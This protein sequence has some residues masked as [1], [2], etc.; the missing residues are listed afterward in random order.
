MNEALILQIKADVTNA[1]RGLSQVQKG[2]TD[3][4]KT[5]SGVS[6][7]G[8]A[9]A[10]RQI[11]QYG[12]LIGDSSGIAKEKINVLESSLRKMVQAGEG[13]T[14]KAEQLSSY[15]MKLKGAANQGGSAF[16]TIS[17]ILK[18]NI[19]VYGQVSNTIEQLGAAF[20]RLAA[21]AGPAA[22]AIAAVAAAYKSV[23]I[24][25]VQFNAMLEQQEI[26]FTAM[27]KSGTQAKIML[28]DL[29]QLSLT[30]PIGLGEGAASAKQLLAYG[31]AQE[32]IISNLKMMKTVAAAVNV[33]LNDLTY[34]YGTLRAQGRAYTRD[35][36]QFAM[37]GI[38]IYEYLA[39]TLGV[40]VGEIKKMTEEGK[41]GFKEVEAA[42]QAMTGEGGKFHGMLEAS[43]DT[44]QGLQTQIK[45][46]WDMFTGEAA[47][48]SSIIFKQLL[49]DILK[50][51]QSLQAAAPTI[52]AAFTIIS[53][54]IYAV[55]KVLMLAVQWVVDFIV[56][57][58]K[59]I[60]FVVD[61]GKA[62]FD[63][64]QNAQFMSPQETDKKWF[65]DM[66][67][68]WNKLIG[69]KKEY[70]NESI[71]KKADLSGNLVD[72]NERLKALKDTFKRTMSVEGIAAFAK[73]WNLSFKDVLDGITN[74]R[75][76]ST[77]TYNKMLKDG[78]A[79][80]AKNR[81]YWEEYT[82]QIDGAMGLEGLTIANG[83]KGQL[84]M[85]D[86]TLQVQKGLWDK[87]KLTK[88]MG[89][90]EEDAKAITKESIQNI[91]D[92]LF[93]QISA[94][95]NN[96]KFAENTE[97]FPLL[98]G[99]IELWKKYNA[100]LETAGKKADTKTKD[101]TDDILAKYA[102]FR[103]KLMVEETGFNAATK[104]LLGAFLGDEAIVKGQFDIYDREIRNINRSYEDMYRS[105]LESGDN[106][107]EKFPLITAMR[108]ADI[109]VV[110]LKKR[111]A[112]IEG[113]M[114]SASH[115]LDMATS[116][117]DALSAYEDQYSAQLKMNDATYQQ[118][119]MEGDINALLNKRIADA[120]ALVKKYQE[121][122]DALKGGS[123]QSMADRTANP[124]FV[125]GKSKRETG[126]IFMEAGLSRDSIKLFTMGLSK[127]LDGLGD[128]I[129]ASMASVGGGTDIGKLATGG[130]PITMFVMALVQAVAEIENVNKVLNFM[131]T[132]MEGVVSMIEGPFNRALKPVVT[133]LMKLGE[134]VGALLLPFIEII[135]ESLGPVASIISVLA[136]FLKRLFIGLKPIIK[137][138]MYLM[139]PLNLLMSLLSDFTAAVG[140]FVS[141]QA[142]ANKELESLYDKEL[143][144]LQN[145]YEVGALSGEQYQER[146]AAL[147]AQYA[148][149]GVDTNSPIYQMVSEMFSFFDDMSASFADMN[150]ALGE[151]WVVLEPIIEPLTTFLVDTIVTLVEI[152][153]DVASGIAD[154]F[155]GI[156]NIVTGI[157]T[158]NWDQVIEG[159]LTMLKGIF[160]TLFSPF[161]DA[162]NWLFRA[163]TDMV[164]SFIVDKN[165]KF[166][167]WVITMPF[168][169]GTGNVPKDMSA[170]I[171][172][173]EGI[174][175]ATFM[176]SIR[177]GELALSA[178]GASGGGNIYVTV[179]N[180][181]SVITER[182][183]NRSIYEGI[184]DLKKRGY[185]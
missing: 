68:A 149:P 85:I 28:S 127:S 120:D 4:Q 30:T 173:G 103:A 129:A 138:I 111:M 42:M 62:F 72:T 142:D 66:E 175:P 19:P 67:A 51:V 94:M 75:E 136:E 58:Q 6:V 163:I 155:T 169:N 50:L 156:S 171:H 82:S 10:F 31:F 164:N 154:V 185:N 119:L 88:L 7:T 176:D 150:T 64:S 158:G 18:N 34:V 95:Q 9:K 38:P 3:I 16:G 174:V 8:T 117:K 131:S 56:N 122:A 92:T 22:I 39:Q 152:L 48:G 161:V 124:L 97:G 33:P 104:G 182:E 121:M 76:T 60:T 184:K 181:G 45:N 29:K 69:K 81:T 55:V 93:A 130:D 5:A 110:N 44:T 27:L 165:K 90:N 73:K 102:D 41:V 35:I 43:M 52:N 172:Q 126:G 114:K 70:A 84:E 112:T 47:A 65:A 166:T 151:L 57:T 89:L 113:E 144:T 177:K 14:K 79:F 133:M 153:T 78:E 11:E 59:L 147:K 99:L 40:S 1:L 135:G 91:V 178:P 145:L 109:A 15:L 125:S 107:A 83:V 116:V 13:G 12:K 168:A 160:K 36:M 2:M 63:A 100:M 132:I 25:G 143:A 49:K 162:L 146:L 128:T 167:P 139:N 80:V 77:E 179:Y 87:E 96:P 98:E 118:A 108:E 23:I 101:I 53:G 71:Y 74:I 180:E 115:A 17:N 148:E 170:Y 137:I 157:L 37:R 141:T 26:A 46:T 106:V 86:S 54:A 20:P 140:A 61:L 105:V 24:P 134:A 123:A 21:A 183:L 32:E 159:F